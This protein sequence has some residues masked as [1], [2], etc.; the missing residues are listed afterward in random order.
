ME[1]KPAKMNDEDRVSMLPDDILL[2]ILGKVDITSAVKTSVLSTR[3]KHL[4]WLLRK[5]TIDVK[6]F[7]PVP[8][9]KPIGV[10]HMDEAMASQT[11]AITSFLSIPRDEFAIDRLQLK[12]Y[13]IDNYYNYSCVI[14]PLVSQ[15]IDNGIL[16]D[17]DITILDEEEITDC[18][19]KYMLQQACAVNN[20]FNAYPG[21]LNCLTRLSLYNVCFAQWDLRHCLFECCNQLRYLSLSNCDVGK[22]AILR[23][24]APNSISVFLN[25][26]YAA[27]GD[28]KCFAFQ[29]WSDSVGTLGFV[30]MPRCHL[31]L[32][33]VLR[34]TNIHTLKLDFQGEKI[35]EHACDE[36]REPCIFGDRLNPAWKVHEDTSFSN[37]LLKELQIVAFRPLKQQLE[38]IRA[39]APNLCAV[40]L[41]YD[42]PCEYCESLGIF[43][44]RSSTECVFPNNKDEQNRVISL[45]K[46]GLRSP[47]EIFFG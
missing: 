11:K 21:V 40:I 46:E 41:K 1:K 18:T 42:D 4:L 22:N 23:I 3:W 27:L 6:D 39:R 8:Q 13:L 25:S 33:H 7:L 17:I 38:F 36:D 15:A 34:N 10:E 32:S 43:P 19:D 47:A 28:L 45:L 24:N 12:L 14:G 20:F 37:S 29:N 30:L 16:K 26:V 5:F 35:W 9:P 44:S 2:F 31:V